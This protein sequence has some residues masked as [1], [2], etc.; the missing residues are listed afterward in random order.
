MNKIAKRCYEKKYSMQKYKDS[1]L[2]GTHDD[3]MDDVVMGAKKEIFDDILVEL[4][5]LDFTSESDLSYLKH[6][7]DEIEKKH[8]H[9]THKEGKK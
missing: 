7:I 8:F 1:I 4:R 6:K 9:L 2:Y 5:K 3:V